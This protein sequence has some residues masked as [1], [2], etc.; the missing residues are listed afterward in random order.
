M[1]LFSCQCEKHPTY[2]TTTTPN[3]VG[4]RYSIR[5]RQCSNVAVGV[6][7]DES[8][9][10]FLTYRRSPLWGK[11]STGLSSFPPKSQ[12]TFRKKRKKKTP[13]N[14]KADC[15]QPRQA[16][17]QLKTD[18]R[19]LRRSCVGILCQ[20]FCCGSQGKISI[21]SETVKQNV[22]RLPRE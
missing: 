10:I 7:S 14:V 9:L 21:F 20:Q 15:F 2:L 5:R 6:D 17:D 12:N 22:G 18:Y 16:N 19:C 3:R 1:K 11:S 13:R 8:S 4:R